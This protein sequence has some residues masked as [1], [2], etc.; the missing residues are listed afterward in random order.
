[1]RAGAV[2]RSSW[3]GGSPEAG[4]PFFEAYLL[5]EPRRP[6]HLPTP[7]GAGGRQGYPGWAPLDGALRRDH[8]LHSASLGEEVTTGGQAATLFSVQ[9]PRFSRLEK[10]ARKGEHSR[11]GGQQVGPP[12]L[13]EVWDHLRRPG[14]A[15]GHRERPCHRQSQRLSSYPGTCS[16]L[17]SGFL[18]PHPLHDL[19][20]GLI[21]ER[22]V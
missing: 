22:K 12:P 1:M 18:A 17:A 20:G 10:V 21:W 8:S 9:Q 4:G 11:G 16:F 3:P 6:A 19:Q 2:S 5:H 15:P 7:P 13:G 14:L